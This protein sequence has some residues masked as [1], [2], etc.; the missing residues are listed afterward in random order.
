MGCGTR[1]IGAECTPWSCGDRRLNRQTSGLHVACTRRTNY[2]L[3]S[4]VLREHRRSGAKVAND[5]PPNLSRRDHSDYTCLAR[6]FRAV[7]SWLLYHGTTCSTGTCADRCKRACPKGSPVW[8]FARGRKVASSRGLRVVAQTVLCDPPS[9][10]WCSWHRPLTAAMS[11][12]II[13]I[14]RQS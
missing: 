13:P 1:R 5:T 6:C 2:V 7:L 8:V 4:C 11:I 12:L 10:P 14:H 3:T 9:R